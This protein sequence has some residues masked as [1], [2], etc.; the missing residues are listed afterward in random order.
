MTY[1]VFGGTLSL[2][3]SIYALTCNYLEYFKCQTHYLITLAQY[4][5]R[6]SILLRTTVC[7]AINNSMHMSDMTQLQGDGHHQGLPVTFSMHIRRISTKHLFSNN[8]IYFWNNN[9]GNS[10]ENY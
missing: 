6:R 9:I 3:Q 10:I 8:F 2:T 7:W 1:N 5:T 4:L